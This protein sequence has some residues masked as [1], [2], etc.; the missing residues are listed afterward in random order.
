MTRSLILASAI[1]VFL[2][3]GAQAQS[4][5]MPRQI[6]DYA[7]TKNGTPYK[8]GFMDVTI[9]PYFPP[10]SQVNEDAGA[11]RAFTILCPG[12]SAVSKGITTGRGATI[13]RLNGEGEGVVLR[14]SARDTRFGDV[15]RTEVNGCVTEGPQVIGPVLAETDVRI[16][17]AHDVSLAL[18]DPAYA[19]HLHLRLGER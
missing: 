4:A 16:T 15:V 18:S 8:T 12:A 11:T 2:H 9:D 17:V 14:V 6:V 10:S 3:G 1:L 5:A 19:L 7:L 13:A